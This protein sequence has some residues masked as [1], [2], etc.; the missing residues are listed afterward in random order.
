M[1]LL[2]I[3]FLGVCMKKIIAMFLLSSGIFFA[4]EQACQEVEKKDQA[5]VTDATKGGQEM[6]KLQFQRAM[7]EEEVVFASKMQAAYLDKIKQKKINS[8]LYR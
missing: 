3:F 2:I 4:A 7:Y 5:A 1:F 8:P 6:Q